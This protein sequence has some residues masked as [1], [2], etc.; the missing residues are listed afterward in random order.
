M[1]LSAHVPVAPVPIHPVFIGSFLRVYFFNF[2]QMNLQT[3]TDNDSLL[4]LDPLLY[5]S[6]SA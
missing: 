3:S 5:M 6:V 4:I 1:P 2:Y